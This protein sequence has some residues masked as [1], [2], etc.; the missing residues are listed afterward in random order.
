MQPK[1]LRHGFQPIYYFSRSIGLWPFTI[2]YNSNGS[3][4]EARVHLFDSF[5][6]LISIS[7]YLTAIFYINK[8]IEAK[9]ESTYLFVNSISNI[10]LHSVG[11]IGIVLDMY[12]RKSLV[13]ILE[14]FSIF[15]REVGLIFSQK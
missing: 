10:L 14:K 2:T 12:N 6:F 1:N 15:D 4:K 3:V 11:A 13:N 5:W 8:R 7:L 9:D